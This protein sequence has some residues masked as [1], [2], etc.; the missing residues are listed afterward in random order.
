MDKYETVRALPFPALAGAL[1][2][3]LQPSKPAR[4]ASIT[5][6]ARCGVF[7]YKNPPRKSAYS[8]RVMVPVEDVDCLSTSS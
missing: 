6:Q 7:S 8:G 5:A 1:G 4:A 3:G 2:L